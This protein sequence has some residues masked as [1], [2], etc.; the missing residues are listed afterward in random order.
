MFLEVTFGWTKSVF[1]QM[2]K[3][4]QMLEQ[5]MFREY[6]F[7]YYYTTININFETHSPKFIFIVK[8]V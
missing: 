6:Y 2:V 5:P 8:R 7:S 1:E 3:R 4:F